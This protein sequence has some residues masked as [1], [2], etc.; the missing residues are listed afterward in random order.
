[1]NDLLRIIQARKESA[2]IELGLW[3]IV[4]GLIGLGVVVGLLID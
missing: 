1:M 3:V 4:L 2:S